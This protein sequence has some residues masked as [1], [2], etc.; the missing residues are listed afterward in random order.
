MVFQRAMI[1]KLIHNISMVL[2][3][4][5]VGVERLGEKTLKMLLWGIRLHTASAR[6]HRFDPWSGNYDSACCVAQL[7]GKKKKKRIWIDVKLRH[8]ENEDKIFLECHCHR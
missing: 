7:F 8:L 1:D 3:L 2:K 6:G 5:G 4:H